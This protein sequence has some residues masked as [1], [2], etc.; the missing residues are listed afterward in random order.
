MD[1]LVKLK[2]GPNQRRWRV[3][4]QDK[5]FDLL[6]QLPILET[7]PEHFLRVL[8]QGSVSTSVGGLQEATEREQGDS[9]A[10]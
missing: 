5:A 4:M 10:D 6:R 2:H 8:Q 7:R 1:E 9:D 3:A